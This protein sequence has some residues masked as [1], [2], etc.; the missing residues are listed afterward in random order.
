MYNDIINNARLFAMFMWR[1]LQV[2]MKSICEDVINY[3]ILFPAAFGISFIY[4]QADIFF[5]MSGETFGSMLFVGNIV[6]PLMVMSYKI[7]FDLVF[8]MEKN[9]F[10][11]YQISLMDPRLIMVQRIL[12]ATWYT[13]FIS[14]LF[15]P[16][17]KIV[18]GGDFIT[19]HASW[20]RVC[21]ILFLGS[22]STVAYHQCFAAFLRMDQIGM[23][24]VRINYVLMV[25]G[26]TFVPT[27]AIKQSSQLLGYLILCNPLLYVTEGIRGALLM[28]NDFISFQVCCAMLIFFSATAIIMTWH[29]FKKRVDHI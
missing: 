2:N 5:S 7:T 13:F 18:L 25:L 15:F 6:I 10:I 20:L 16:V 11:D 24:W 1:D 14:L 12:F 23:F 26:G 29:I 27:M 17:S 19:C 28:T 4:L 3:G 9:R 21:T 22:L 8:D